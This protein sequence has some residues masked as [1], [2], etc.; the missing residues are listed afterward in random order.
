MIVIFPNSLN[1]TVN[2]IMLGVFGVWSVW[3][4]WCLEC[5]VFGVCR[6]LFV[7]CELAVSHV[8][9]ARPLQPIT[10]LSCLDGN[11][12]QSNLPVKTTP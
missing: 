2:S 1:P 4:V 11:H 7:Q 5:L 6:T 8:T 9:M 3:S 12:A 10:K